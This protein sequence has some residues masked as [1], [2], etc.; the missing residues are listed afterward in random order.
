MNAVNE[1]QEREWWEGGTSGGSV[2]KVG[3]QD[4]ENLDVELKPLVTAWWFTKRPNFLMSKDNVM[5]WKH[6][7]D[8]KNLGLLPSNFT[9]LIIHAVNTLLCNN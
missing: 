7:F 6:A 4:P 8:I 3:T 5:E 9:L 2:C 1:P